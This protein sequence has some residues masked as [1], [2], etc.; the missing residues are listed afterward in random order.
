MDDDPRAKAEL[1]RLREAIDRVDRE[2]LAKLNERAGFVV[3]VGQLK[4]S[5]R[6]PVYVAGRERDLVA[7][8]EAENPGPFPEAGIA[9]V[10]REIISATRSLEER[11]RVAFL[12]PEGTFSELAGRRQFGA[13]VDLVPARS[14]RE[15]VALTE[16]G[17]TNFSVIPVENTTEGAVTS[18]IDALVDAEVTICGELLLEISLHL[19]NQSG[20]LADV[21]RVTSNPQPLAQCRNWLAS[22]LPNAEIFESA[23][24][25]AAAEVAVG[26]REVGAI[27]S[28]IIAQ[29]FGLKVVARNIEDQRG[30]TTR[31]LVV[32]L[33]PPAPS[34]NDLTSAV[35]TVRR[36]QS[37]ALFHLLEPFARY[38]VSLTSLQSRP[39]L[40]KPWEYL[41]FLDM[42]GHQHDESIAKALDEAATLASSHKILGSFPRAKTKARLGERRSP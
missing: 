15:V 22:Q 31:F 27:G 10:F 8:L 18:S 4:R 12:G 17:D 40:G 33:E 6:S 14:M 39:M 28:E 26:D 16:R 5:T 25:A 41:F 1:A 36:D 35:F 29:T 24:T 20:E 37:G 7:Q 9:P 34:G 13:Q 32:G 23:S 21:R 11:V 38:D 3:E 19:V 30:N 2:L 42:E